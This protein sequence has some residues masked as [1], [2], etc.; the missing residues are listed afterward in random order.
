MVLEALGSV[1]NVCVP[2]SFGQ[3]TLGQV[4]Q[5]FSDLETLAPAAYGTCSAACW[6]HQAKACSNRTTQAS[7]TA[8]PYCV[9]DEE[10]AR[11]ASQGLLV[12]IAESSSK[13]DSSFVD[14]EQQAD[15]DVTAYGSRYLLA[16]TL[17]PKPCRHKSQE[18][19]SNNDVDRAAQKVYK[20]CSA[21]ATQAAC[22]AVTSAATAPRTAQAV[23]DWGRYE[24]SNAT[25]KC[26]VTLRERGV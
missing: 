22:L 5:T 16:K 23:F 13:N 21:A 7:C 6:L 15:D 14:I 12:R 11:K 4:K 26:S 17:K 8:L 2:K 25:V 9:F 10:A 20:R 24:Q 3:Q 19:S 1:R 18:F